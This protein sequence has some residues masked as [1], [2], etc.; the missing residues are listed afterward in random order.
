MRS[1]TEL[2]KALAKAAEREYGAMGVV[3]A[4]DDEHVY[5]DSLNADAEHV[6]LR[7]WVPPETWKALD[8]W[9]E[10]PGSEPPRLALLPAKPD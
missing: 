10:H 9:I 2:V 7:Y 1:H 6:I 8:S 4:D 3:L 5:M